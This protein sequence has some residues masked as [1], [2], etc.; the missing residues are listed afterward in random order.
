MN[1]TAPTPYTPLRPA[2]SCTL[3]VRGLD[4]HLLR[5][6]EPR[7]DQPLLVLAHGWMDVAAS[8]QFLVDALPPDYAI[9]APDWRGFGA[10]VVPQQIDHFLF[11]DYLLDLDYLLD[12]LSP[13]QPVDLVGHSMG[14]NIATQYAG[15]RPE[16]IRKLV[17]LEGFGLP[18]TQAE[19]AP[20]RLRDWMQQVKAQR[21]GEK[22]LH[23]YPDQSSVAARLQKTNPRLDDAKAL[24]LASQWAQPQADGRWHIRAHAAH[25]VPSAHLYHVAEADAVL[26]RI[27]APTLSISASDDS[28]AAFWGERYTQAEYLQR[29]T[30]IATLRHAVV[31]DAGHMLHHDQPAA[32][33]TLIDAFLQE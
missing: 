2:R 18:A 26:R 31:Q 25:K 12:Q 9:V 8:Y 29:M 24:W 33:A 27:Q 3:P 32:L 7:V 11:A 1:T 28:L 19:Q 23:S 21:Q 4:Y 30:A 15:L 14:G 13:Q 17:N 10:T 6:G 5:W 16:R 22:Q 20:G